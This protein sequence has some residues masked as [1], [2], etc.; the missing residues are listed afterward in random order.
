MSTL[1]HKRIFTHTR[2]LPFTGYKFQRTVSIEFFLTWN[3]VNEK[4]HCIAVTAN[5]VVFNIDVTV[6]LSLIHI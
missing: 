1:K 3:F 5:A 4:P 2:V 6:L